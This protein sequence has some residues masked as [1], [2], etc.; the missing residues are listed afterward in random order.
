MGPSTCSTPG[1]TRRLRPSTRA[2]R[3]R[4]SRLV[5]RSRPGPLR[6]TQAE[7]VPEL[8]DITVYLDRLEALLAGQPL[9]RVQLVS[10]FVLRSVD[11]PVKAL[12]GRR[13]IAFRRLGKRIVIGFDG[14]GELFLV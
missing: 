10:P 6:R 11:P 9:E 1:P 14:P 5:W 4:R 3:R 7:P 2:G 12:E 13:P 8:P